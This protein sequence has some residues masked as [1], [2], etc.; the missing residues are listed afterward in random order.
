M[1]HLLYQD[2]LSKKL[3]LVTSITVKFPNISQNTIRI[4]IK[5]DFTD[6]DLYFLSGMLLFYLFMI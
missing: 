4:D 2:Y 6:F 3:N 5:N 1:Q